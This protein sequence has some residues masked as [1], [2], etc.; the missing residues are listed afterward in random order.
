MR[1]STRTRHDAK[2]GAFTTGTPC[3]SEE[4]MHTTSETISMAATLAARTCDGELRG[5][6]L[7]QK[8]RMLNGAMRE[9][10]ALEKVS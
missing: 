7:Q 9:L 6:A 1:I 10:Q 4:S 5:R 2:I 8:S 3:A